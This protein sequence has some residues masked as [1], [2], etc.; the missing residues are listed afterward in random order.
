MR[1]GTTMR[2][3]TIVNQAVAA[4]ALATGAKMVGVYMKE[5]GYCTYE[6]SDENG[7]AT[8]AAARWA[9]NDTMIDAK[10]FTRA[11]AQIVAA[12]S[13]RRGTRDRVLKPQQGAT[14]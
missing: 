6:F 1:K 10:E 3:R 13:A 12:T 7:E 4:F 9:T 11:F 8:R 2:N 5:D 14:A